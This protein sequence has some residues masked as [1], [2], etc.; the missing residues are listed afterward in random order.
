M[1][2]EVPENK[3][4]HEQWHQMRQT[5]SRLRPKNCTHLNSWRFPSMSTTHTVQTIAANALQ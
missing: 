4:V 5:C 3:G 2:S 1:L